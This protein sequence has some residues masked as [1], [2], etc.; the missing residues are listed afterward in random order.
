MFLTRFIVCFVLL[1][2]PYFSALS[3]GHIATDSLQMLLNEACSKNRQMELL[4]A[5]SDEAAKSDIATSSKFAHQGLILS[6]SLNHDSF[7]A[8]FNAVIAHNEYH[9]GNYKEA[10]DLYLKSLI[11]YERINDIKGVIGVNVNLGAI[12]DRLSDEK[13]ALAYYQKALTDLNSKGQF[14]LKER[15]EFKTVLYNNIASIYN[16]L[17]D[18]ARYK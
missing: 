2:G 18:D 8:Q 5:L 12:Y 6:Q 17:G 4:K 11:I 3:Q 9:L 15:P 16:I 1:N 14:I 10:L 13:R 7:T